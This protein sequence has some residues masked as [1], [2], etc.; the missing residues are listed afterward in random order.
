MTATGYRLRG[1]SLSEQRSEEEETVKG[2]RPVHRALQGA[3]DE[4]PPFA[5]RA[6][7]AH[8]FRSD[9]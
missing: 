8:A 3:A 5:P 1:Q 4:T 9:F 6:A 2:F 7:A